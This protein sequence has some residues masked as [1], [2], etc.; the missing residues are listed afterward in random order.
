MYQI[1]ISQSAEKEMDK[2]PLKVNRRLDIAI[3]A[4]AQNPRPTGCKK[5]KGVHESTWRIRVGDY[6]IIYGVDD[7]I[8]IIDIRKVGHRKDIYD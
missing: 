6:H 5:L 4:L 7:T 8:K 2:L 1:L 3:G